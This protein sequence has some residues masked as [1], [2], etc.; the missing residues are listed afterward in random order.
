MEEGSAVFEWAMGGLLIIGLIAGVRESCKPANLRPGIYQ[1]AI[2]MNH[3]RYV[4]S[5]LTKATEHARS[6]EPL[7]MSF[8][9]QQA[10]NLGDSKT[11]EEAR[12][13]RQTYFNP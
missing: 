6:G 11:Q 10:E 2:E 1:T 13:I 3:K 8:Y 7:R 5:L 9:L 4:T 12:R